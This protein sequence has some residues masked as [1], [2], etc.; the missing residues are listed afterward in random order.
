MSYGELEG[1]FGCFCF[2]NLFFLL[3]LGGWVVGCSAVSSVLLGG[4]VQ[5]KRIGLVVSCFELPA[6]EVLQAFHDTF[7]PKYPPGPVVQ[8][9]VARQAL[10]WL[11]AG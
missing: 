7:E 11:D 5:L 1:F 8:L 4:L 3:F 10:A 2:S 6:A 9:M